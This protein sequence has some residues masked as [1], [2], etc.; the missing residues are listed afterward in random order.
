MVHGSREWGVILI[1]PLHLVK[2]TKTD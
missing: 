2:K 1:K